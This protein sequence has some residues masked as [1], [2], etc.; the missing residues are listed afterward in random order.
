M[1]GLLS[2]LESLGLD[3]LVGMN[4]YEDPQ[5]EEAKKQEEAKKAD[6]IQIEKDFIFDKS[7]TC[8]VCDRE[9]KAKTAKVGRAK[10]LGQDMDLRPR[11]EG[12]DM[13]KYDAIVCPHC[14]YAAL[15]RYYKYVS[16]KQAQRIQETISKSYKAKEETSEIYTYEM[17]L[18]RHKLVLAN[19]IVKQAKNSEKA[20]ICLK[21]AWLLRGQTENIP[22]DDPEFDKKKIEGL[23]SE[24]EFLKNALDGFI[25]ARQTEGYPMCG[26]DETTVDY[27][28]AVLSLRFNQFDV[29]SKLIAGILTSTSANPRMKD[30]ARDLKETLMQKIKE[31]KAGKA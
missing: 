28:L 14:G 10:L 25:V 13:L 30:R 2:G 29:S 4:L 21:T 15:S 6:P 16:S 31:Q 8:P 19:A 27:L 22:K 1:A 7:H 9:F 20:Y 18:E 3:N 23:K 17:A 26:M 12:I 5:A 11:Y 24:E